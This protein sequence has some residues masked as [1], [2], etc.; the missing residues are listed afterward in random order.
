M[1]VYVRSVIQEISLIF[2][3]FFMVLLYLRY[4]YYF[5]ALNWYISFPC[6]CSIAHPVISYNWI[7][8]IALCFQVITTMIWFKNILS[9]L[10]SILL[11]INFKNTVLQS[12]LFC[13]FVI[14]CLNCFVI[15]ILTGSQVIISSP[16]LTSDIQC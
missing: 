15:L 2:S 3:L 7:Y 13:Q 4:I 11:G 5:L 16:Y 9:F 10:P 8:I 6:Y 12:I 1:F 14:Y